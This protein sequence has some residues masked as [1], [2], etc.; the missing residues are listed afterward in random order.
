MTREKARKASNILAT[1][2][3]VDSV[4]DQVMHIQELPQDLYQ[5]LIKDV[6]DYKHRLEKEL[7][8]L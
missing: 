3:D 1:L 4:I 7:D 2:E 6:Y 8:E 5:I